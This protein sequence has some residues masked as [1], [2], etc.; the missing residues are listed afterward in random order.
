[1]PATRDEYGAL[2]FH[3]RDP[4]A[5]RFAV[6]GRHAAYRWDTVVA[7]ADRCDLL[8]RRCHRIHHATHGITRTRNAGS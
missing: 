2:D 6:G 1:M 5:K 7:E 4:T 3:R 8:C